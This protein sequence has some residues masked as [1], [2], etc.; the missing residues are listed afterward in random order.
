MISHDELL[1][2]V[3]AYALGVLPPDEAAAVQRHLQ[4]C[5]ECRAEYNLLRPA[6]TAVAYSAEACTDAASGGTVASP[7]LKARIMKQVR[8]EAARQTRPRVAWPAYL[9]A[10]ACLALAI[11]TGLQDLS[12]NDRLSRDRVQAAQQAQMIADMMAPDSKRMPFKHGE[13]LMRGQR[14]YIAMHDMPMPPRG[15][16]YQAWT[17]A[18][19]TKRVAPSMTF[20]PGSNSMTIVR[21]PD[22]T[23]TLAAVAVSIEPEGGSQQPTSKPIA[24]VAL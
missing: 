24:M 19:G 11:I 20:M 18:K 23:T 14:L 7:L 3:A 22:A 21:L 16:V 8:A 6:V 17:L 2:N 13:V 9:F 10:A 12:L 4:T 5:E 1:D 15:K